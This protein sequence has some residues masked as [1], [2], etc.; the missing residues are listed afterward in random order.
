MGRGPK[1][2]CKQ[3]LVHREFSSVFFVAVYIPPQTNAGTKTALN[4]LYT[5][6]SKQEN[7]H[8]EAKLLVAGDLNAGKLK[9]VLPNF[10]QHVTC[11]T[12]GEKIQDHIYSTHKALPRPRPPFGKYDHNVFLLIPAY[13]QK[14]KQ[15]APESWSIKNVVR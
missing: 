11:A 1:H 9:S 13:K 10:Y 8:P 7:A 6:I 14:L 2:V 3:Q 15:E 4:E 12:R 5:A